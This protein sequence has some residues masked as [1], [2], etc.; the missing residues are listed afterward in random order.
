[1][2]L[3][4]GLTQW[5]GDPVLPWTVVHR[6]GLDPAL[7]WLW[8]WLWPA[9]AALIRPL[10]WELPYAIGVV[11]KSKTKQNKTKQK[12]Q[13]QKTKIHLNK[14]MPRP[15]KVKLPKTQNKIL[16]TLKETRK[17]QHISHRET[18]F[19]W[20]QSSNQKLWKA[21]NS[22]TIYLKCWGKKSYQP[23]IT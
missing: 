8:L 14:T 23:R 16:K 13:K 3:N 19:E 11:L 20:I 6:Q 5:V 22:W 17:K 9:A 15:I 2:G 18:F 7:L 10:A 1:M 4:P 21:Q 12:T